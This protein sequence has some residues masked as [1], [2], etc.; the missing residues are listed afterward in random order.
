[1]NVGKGLFT[2]WVNPRAFEA[3]LEAK[4][5]EAKD[6]D[7]AALKNFIKYWK[8]LDGVAISVAP[9]KSLDVQLALK[10]RTEALPASARKFFGEAA[11]ASDLWNA[12]PPDA[13][14]AV[15]GRV[16]GP[17]LLEML[18]EFMTEDARKAMREALQNSPVPGLNKIGR[19]VF[20][21]LGPEIGFCIA[22]PPA[23]DKGWF[24]HMTWAI[25][26]RPGKEDMPIEQTLMDGLNLFATLMV[27]DHNSKKPDR[28]A[29][30]NEMQDKVD[31]RFLV[32]D[33]LFPVGV[34]PAYALKAG[35]LLF[36]SSPEVVNRFEPKPAKEAPAGDAL[37]MR[38]SLVTLHGYLKERRETIA[39]FMVERHQ[40]TKE[41]A[42]QRIDA[43]LAG[44]QFFQSVEMSQRSGPNHAV[45][46]FRI[47]TTQPLR[48]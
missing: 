12:F 4:A 29:I 40:V 47:K 28:I 46:T 20:P 36:T 18:G 48:K 42:G 45:L 31:V 10:V 37:L 23:Q 43:W 1:L 16:D 44:L 11:Q 41:E 2:V 24:P 25:R 34:R 6:A 22:A 32:S 21:F 26:V 30:K 13:L 15:A 39:A 3:D 9:A 35:Y 8:A 14:L 33:K 5:K 17:A 19:E 38:A 7:A 27:F